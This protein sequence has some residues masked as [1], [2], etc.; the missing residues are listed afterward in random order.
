MP[1]SFLGLPSS[2]QAG[3]QALQHQRFFKGKEE[4][5]P[6]GGDE[7]TVI[8]GVDETKV[9]SPPSSALV[10]ERCFIIS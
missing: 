5:G 10:G 8:S 1:D 9:K 3:A 7:K 4:D 2:S 6:P